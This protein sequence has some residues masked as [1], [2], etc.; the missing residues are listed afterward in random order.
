[1]DKSKKKIPK[2]CRIGDTCFTSFVTIGSNLY[3]RH[4]KSINHVHRHSN[5]L[6]SLI[7]VL[8]TDVNG[9][10]TVFNDEDKMN[11]IGKR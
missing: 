6:L 1:M 9:G 8:G 2:E 4:P 7:I 3:T 5:N 10:K 11:D